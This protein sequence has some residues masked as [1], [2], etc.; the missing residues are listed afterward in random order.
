MKTI[1]KNILLVDDSA[2]NIM[3]MEAILEKDG[4]TFLTALSGKEALKILLKEYQ[5]V[6]KNAARK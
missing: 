5:T 3:S 1:I 6:K 4:Y 2:D